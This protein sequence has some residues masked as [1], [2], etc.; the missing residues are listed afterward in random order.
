MQRRIASRCA[1]ETAERQV[2]RGIDMVGVVNKH[3]SMARHT[4]VGRR[5]LTVSILVAVCV[6]SATALSGAPRVAAASP[7]DDWAMFHRDL[8]HQGVSPDVVPGASTASALTLK[9]KTAVPGSSSGLLGSPAV[10]YNSTLG[11]DLVYEASQ[12]THSTLMAIDASSGVPVWSTK[13]TGAIRDSVAV[14]GNTVYVGSHNAQ[15]YAVNATTGQIV[16]TY[17]TTGMIEA[18]PVV[19]NV[20][21]TGD[22]VF[23][24]D[25]GQG[26][27]F[28]AGHLWAINGVGNTN[29]QCTLKWSFN[30]FA[31]TV[32]GTR[33]GS[34][35]PPALV[36][37]SGVW[38]VVFGTT[39][40]D[41][42]VYALNAA[43]GAALWHYTTT[44]TGD[45]DVGAGPTISPPGVN[46]FTDGVVYVDGKDQVEYALNLA[47]GSLIWQFN[48]KKNA[49]SGAKAICTAALVGTNLIITYNQYVYD[50]NAL[51]GA[52]T[53][54][55]VATGTADFIASPAISGASGNQVI[56]AGDLAGTEHAYSLATGTQVFAYKAAATIFASSAIVNGMVFFA[57][58]DG[59]VYA[60][61]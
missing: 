21:G 44:T 38:R 15:L 20:D 19:G 46:G 30:S 40:P 54:R 49:G 61:G 13:L 31:V 56:F 58:L 43:T 33:T 34:W 7:A 60:L 5:R 28:N 57:G 1:Q 32:G 16:C 48:L 55:S 35:S 4:S 12:G 39:N 17:T 10:V 9:W 47:T 14:S 27:K 26:E 59:Y 8:Q 11:K 22:V 51:N 36:Q 52:L 41:E 25:I 50:L 24:G 29:G 53:W 45:S 18:S 3:Q 23:F 2:D 37:V 42:A 6:G